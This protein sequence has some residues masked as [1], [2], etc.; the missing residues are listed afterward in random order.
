MSAEKSHLNDFLTALTGQDGQKNADPSKQDT[1]RRKTTPSPSETSSNHFTLVDINKYEHCARMLQNAIRT[2]VNDV[3]DLAMFNDA[4]NNTNL[5]DFS[6][7]AIHG[8]EL[9]EWVCGL[10]KKYNSG[11]LKFFDEVNNTASA[12]NMPDPTPNRT[13]ESANLL[14][15]K[16]LKAVQ[17]A[18]NDSAKKTSK[19]GKGLPKLPEISDNAL[20]RR[21]FIHKSLTKNKTYL[22][23]EEIVQLHYERLEFLGDSVLHYITTVLLFEKFPY[24]TEGF[25]TRWRSRLVSNKTLAKFSEQYKFDHKLQ[26][27]LDETQLVAGREKLIA[28][29]FEAYIGALAIDLHLNLTPIRVWLDQ[30]LKEEFFAAEVEAK[31]EISINKDAKSQ[32]Y[33][34]IGSAL[35]HPTYKV[36]HIGTAE[37]PV[38]EVHCVMEGETLGVGKA[39][40]LKDAGLRAAMNALTKK[41]RVDYYIKSR[42]KTDRSISVVKNTTNEQ[43][44]LVKN[45]AETNSKFPLIADSSVLAHKFSKN[46]VH[47]FLGQSMGM[48][49]EYNS[50]FDDKEKRYTCELTV[51]GF[52]L[53]KAY[54]GSKKKGEMR[55]AT[56][57][58]Q[59]KHLLPEMMSAI[60]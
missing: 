2:I 16:E 8:N 48:T 29:I 54:D 41:E 30:L 58:L 1:K 15:S 10:K 37:T 39:P 26:S 20:R 33:S 53:T 22:K 28:D 36:V 44:D 18:L 19:K 55:A 25:M 31:S 5:D 23:D 12:S 6:K 27:R 47:A 46:E 17:N 60:L 52:T 14:G 42:L 57:L 9:L 21:V 13:N 24:A 3:P 32:L 56:L 34:L 35:L 50:I 4:I 49:A 40:N 59:N 45:Q 7:E 38:Y 51:N 11:D 43:E